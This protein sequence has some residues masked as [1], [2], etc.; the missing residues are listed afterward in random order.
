MTILSDSDGRRLYGMRFEWNRWAL[1]VDLPLKE[2]AYSKVM[3][4]QVGRT[5]L[6]SKRSREQVGVIIWVGNYQSALNS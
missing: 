6:M 4:I 1:M 2:G 3:L 5:G